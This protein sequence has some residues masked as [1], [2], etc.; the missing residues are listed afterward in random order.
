MVTALAQQQQFTTKMNIPFHQS[1]LLF[2]S[3]PSL[4]QPY[5]FLIISLSSCNFYLQSILFTVNLLMGIFGSINSLFYSM[6]PTKLSK[7][8]N[9]HLQIRRNIVH[10]SM[11]VQFRHMIYIF[12][13]FGSTV[14]SRL[15]RWI[16]FS[17]VQVKLSAKT[18]IPTVLYH[19]KMKTMQNFLYLNSKSKINLKRKRNWFNLKKNSDKS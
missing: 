11:I 10:N 3:Y 8:L 1:V 7:S 17:R 13:L 6:R 15:H 19:S 4:H 14:Q 5:N 2:L 18:M 12:T 16:S 9:I